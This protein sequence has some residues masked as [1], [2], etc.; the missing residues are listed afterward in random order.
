M[1]GLWCN[2]SIGCNRRDLSVLGCEIFSISEELSDDWEGH[3]V[4][5]FRGCDATWSSD[6]L[7]KY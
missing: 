6:I 4:S 5:F 7:N 1:Q 2:K 3:V